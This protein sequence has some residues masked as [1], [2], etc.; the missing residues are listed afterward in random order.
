MMKVTSALALVLAAV[1][2]AYGSELHPMEAG[3]I[4]LGN[5]VGTAYYTMEPDGLRIVTTLALEEGAPL[6]FSATL[7]ADQKVMLSVP[8]AAGEPSLDLEFVRRGDV[9]VISDME[10]VATLD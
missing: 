3:R 5:V 7:A 2:A 6:R 8:Q 10:T 1:S 9:I 4:N